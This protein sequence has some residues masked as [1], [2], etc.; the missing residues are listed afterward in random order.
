MYICIFD[1]LNMCDLTC[2]V[3]TEMT[4]AGPNS[5]FYAIFPFCHHAFW[6][7]LVHPKLPQGFIHKP[8]FTC[9]GGPRGHSVGIRSRS[10]KEKLLQGELLLEAV[11]LTLTLRREAKDSANMSRILG[12]SHQSST[13]LFHLLYPYG[14]GEGC[15]VACLFVLFCFI[16][17]SL[18]CGSS[19]QPF[20]CGNAHKLFL[21]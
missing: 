21:F 11:C 13:S 19:W 20:F 14:R 9:R 18:W 16:S 12:T 4:L 3:I 6:D 17:F 2:M 7:F 8:H 5:I 1:G 15:I 10:S